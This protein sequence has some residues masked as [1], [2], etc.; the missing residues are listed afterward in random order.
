MTAWWIDSISSGPV[1][2]IPVAIIA[3]F[4]VWGAISN[5]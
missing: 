1:P 2:W 5:G 4:F 3:A